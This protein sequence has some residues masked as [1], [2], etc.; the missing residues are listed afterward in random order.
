M[1]FAFGQTTK[2]E[3]ATD[4]QTQEG[5]KQPKPGQGKPDSSMGVGQAQGSASSLTR[6]GISAGRIE[7]RDEATQQEKTGQGSAEALAALN[8]AITSEADAS[9]RLA[10]IF[11]KDKVAKDIGA[12]VHIGKEFGKVAPK[13]IAD[14]AEGQLAKAALLEKQAQ[15]ESDP[16]KQ[17]ELRQQAQSLKNTW[18]EGKPGRLA[19]H[20]FA[21][22]LSGGLPA[23]VGALS[24]QTLIPH[25]DEA[26][27]GQDVPQDL[28][29]TLLS[30]AGLG[31][32]A[33]TGGAAGAAAGLN[34]TDNNYLKHHEYEAML[35]ELGQCQGKAACDAVFSKYKQISD[36]NNAGLLETVAKGDI[37]AN[38]E[39]TRDINQV[40][41]SGIVDKGYQQLLNMSGKR[42]LAEQF[43]QFADK[44]WQMDANGTLGFGQT[45]A[46]E[47]ARHANKELL[48]KQYREGKIDGTQF[49]GG[50]TGWH[51]MKTVRICPL[52]CPRE[53][54]Y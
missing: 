29:N 16:A 36:K 19:A 44:S 51:W 27:Q 23:A 33:A 15:N 34:I 30:A 39:V 18:G 49:A 52:A 40:F 35:K 32:G 5:D 42:D 22:G 3:Q 1:G 48:I 2:P 37:Q 20:A 10:P 50:L 21:A 26:L 24:S 12:Q 54:M 8:T 14:Y 38:R 13:A 43:A 41:D 25:L 47:L 6:S 53:S 46:D 7:I 9:Q 31:I 45:S 28:R 17:N 11:D 4:K